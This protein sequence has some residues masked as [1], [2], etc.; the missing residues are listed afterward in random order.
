[1]KAD[2]HFSVQIYRN[3]WIYINSRLQKVNVTVKFRVARTDRIARMD[4]GVV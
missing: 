1:V 4:C 2:T 3:C